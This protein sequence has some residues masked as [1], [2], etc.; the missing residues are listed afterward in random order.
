MF[1]I[2]G[3]YKVGY[4]GYM[5]FRGYVMVVIPAIYNVGYFRDVEGWLF[6]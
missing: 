5:I 2:Q 1:V 6:Q 3:I 4:F